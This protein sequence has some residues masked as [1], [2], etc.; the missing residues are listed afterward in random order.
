MR[1]KNLIEKMIEKKL[2]GYYQQINTFE[3]NLPLKTE[4]KPTVAIIGAGLAGLSAAIILAQRG[5]H[6][7]IYEKDNFLG[8]KVGSWPHTFS[9]GYSTR[10]EHGFHA[11]FRQYYNLRRLLE[12]VG[13]IDN[14]IPISDYMIRTL[15]K[16]DYSFKNI[17]TTPILNLLSMRKSKVYGFA[18]ILKNPRFNRMLQLLQYDP[19]K[20]FVKYDNMS[21]KEFADNVGLGIP[22][23]LMFTTF[24]RAFF[25]EPQLISMGEL[26]K[27]FHFYFLSNDHGLLYDVL[28]DDFKHTLLDPIQNFLAQYPVKI[29]LKQA[30]S[31]ISQDKD[32]FKVSDKMYDYLI[33]ASDIGGTKG[34]IVR[35]TFIE[36]QYPNF[37]NQM[38]RQKRSQKYAVLRIWI[39]KDLSGDFPFFIFTDAIKI[40]DSITIYHK[41]ENTSALWVKQNGGG[42]FELHSYALPETFQDRGEIQSQLLNEFET[43]FP[44][45]KG[46]TI[47]YDNLQVRDDFTAFHT[48]LHNNRPTFKTEIPNLYLAGDWVKI[49]CPAMLM[50][51]ATTSAMYCTNEILR[52][53]NLRQEPIYSVPL[54]GI[55]S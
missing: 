42:I 8:G 28:N 9:D 6:V 17:K 47:K 13:V 24:A 16:G 35:S 51:A 36:E 4:K 11:F 31:H 32:T 30:V 19:Y 2:G 29:F 49:P 7:D 18:D 39:D 10:I 44:E 54:K 22:M 33:M 40:L 45:I 20:T 1:G 41:M 25:A 37:F 21:F 48:N 5:F 50:E 3:Q 26:I 14:L 15:D 53:E 38:K 27:S 55:F 46:Y 23:R 34:I 52:S 12:Q 43:Y